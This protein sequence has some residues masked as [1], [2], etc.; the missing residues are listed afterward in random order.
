MWT[1]EQEVIQGRFEENGKIFVFG[2]KSVDTHFMVLTKSNVQILWFY[3]EGRM[4]D[5]FP[6]LVLNSWTCLILF[7]LIKKYLVLLNYEY[8]VNS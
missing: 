5:T 8:I 2:G 4:L 3:C 6:I 1:F 7:L